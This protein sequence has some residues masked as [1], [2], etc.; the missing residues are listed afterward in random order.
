MS[1]TNN[2]YQPDVILFQIS[3]RTKMTIAL[4]LAWFGTA[5]WGICF[6]WMHRLS[7]RQEMML[8]ELHD[9]TKRIEKLSKAEHD[10][11][12]DVHPKVEEI[13]ESVKDV[14]QKVSAQNR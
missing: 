7:A 8:K 14:S 4:L 6:W 11:I 13:K 9:V 12:Q 10:L 1:A 5:C 3:F 2:A